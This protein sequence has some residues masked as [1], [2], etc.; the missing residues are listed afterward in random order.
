MMETGER[1]K[2][3]VKRRTH[4]HTGGIYY[5]AKPPGSK[6]RENEN[7]QEKSRHEMLTRRN[8]KKKKEETTRHLL[9][10]LILGIILG[11]WIHSRM[12]SVAM[13][14]KPLYS[15]F[16]L[17]SSSPLCVGHTT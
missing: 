1:V 15:G 7:R 9:A 12:N 17:K 3:D 13:E 4:T 10:S 2:V 11:S 5:V 14:S 8:K 16:S 6:R